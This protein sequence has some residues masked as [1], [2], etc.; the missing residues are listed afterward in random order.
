MKKYVGNGLNSSH[1]DHKGH[2][3]MGGTSLCHFRIIRG[4]N[5]ASREDRET[6]RSLP[7]QRI[8]RKP[9]PHK[10]V[11]SVSSVVKTRLLSRLQNREGTYALEWKPRIAQRGTDTMAPAKT[12]QDSPTRRSQYQIVA[13]R[14]SQRRSVTG[15]VARTVRWM[16]CWVNR[17]TT[18]T[19]GKVPPRSAQDF[20]NKGLI[21]PFI[22]HNSPSFHA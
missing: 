1:R 4:T 5:E 10:S 13:R 18:Q 6:Q 17:R 3:K 22:I 19:A 11:P 16:V 9:P 7:K 8:T 15:R 20:S 12:D 2:K 21:H 14:F